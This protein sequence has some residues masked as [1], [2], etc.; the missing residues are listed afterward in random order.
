MHIIITEDMKP[1]TAWSTRQY[2]ASSPPFDSEL[3]EHSQP[4]GRAPG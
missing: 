4:A 1:V 3:V 2:R